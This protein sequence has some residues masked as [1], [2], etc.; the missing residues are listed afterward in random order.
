MT[1]EKWW[2]I[3]STTAHV[4]V[5]DAGA[6][7]AAEELIRAELRSIELA[8]SR[9]RDDSELSTVAGD[10]PTVVSDVLAHLVRCALSAAEVTG[11]AVDPTVG[12]AVIAR[13]YDRNFTALA[14]AALSTTAPATER[15]THTVSVV[16]PADWTMVSL[17]D[18]VLT[19]P[20]G[21]VLDLGATAKAVAADRCADLV[22]SSL[23]CGVLVSLG[24]DI[25]TRGPAPG[26]GWHVRVCDATGEPSTTI[27]VG[28]G[29]GIATSS[30]LHRRWVKSGRN[31]HHIFDPS[32]GWPVESYWRTATVVADTA[33]EANTVSTACIVKGRG[34]VSWLS[35]T[36]LPVRLVGPTGEITHTRAWPVDAAV[37]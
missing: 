27:C 16:R 18:R 8:C 13:G 28:S 17:H 36:A 29:A 33:L 22:S 34:A 32:S 4:I 2:D 21:V 35:S 11:G 7:D 25:A 19:V 24:G 12:S 37:A 15:R 14:T 20:A 10:T 30:T 26:G 6:L 31:M 23:G 1:S 3:W 9:F 5:T